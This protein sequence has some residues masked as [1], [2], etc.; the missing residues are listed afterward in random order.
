MS[1]VTVK[2]LAEDVG[3]PVDLLLSQL[4]EAGLKK[5]DADDSVSEEEK[6]QLLT[7]LRESHGKKKESA[8]TGRKITLDQVMRRI[9]VTR[10]GYDRR[11]G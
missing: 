9:E 10:N 4:D 8:A 7:H 1:E 5:V 11:T 3:I 6:L 2:Q